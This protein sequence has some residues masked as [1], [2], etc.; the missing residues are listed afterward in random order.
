MKEDIRNAKLR[1]AERELMEEEEEE[2]RR[3]RTKKVH[4]DYTRLEDL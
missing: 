1:R 3:Q 2:E 4:E